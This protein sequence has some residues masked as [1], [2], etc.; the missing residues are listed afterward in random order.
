VNISFDGKVALVTG[1][2]SGLGLATAKAFAEAGASVALAD[3]N[4]DAVRAAADE[5]TAQGRKAL[6]I[7][8]ACTS[9]MRNKQF[10]PIRSR[11]RLPSPSAS[12]TT[13]TSTKSCSGRRGKRFERDPQ[14]FSIGHRAKERRYP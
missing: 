6:G 7:R 1:A 14:L 3:C 13:W 2:A 4:E 12:R 9:S 11:V 10:P 8:R 5:L